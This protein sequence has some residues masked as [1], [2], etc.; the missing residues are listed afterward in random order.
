MQFRVEL[1]NVQH[2]KQLALEIDL[3]L[4]KITCLVGRNGTGKTTL[5]RALRNL[6]QSDTFLRTARA[7]IFG[8]DSVIRYFVEGEQITFDYDQ[9]LQNLNFKGNISQS[10]QDLC[11]VELPIPDGERFNF[12]QSISRA[13]RHIRRQIILEEYDRP[14]EL[15]EFLSTIY[16]T[17]KFRSLVETRIGPHSYYCILLEE[18]RYVREDYLSSGEYFLISLYRMIRGT[19]RLIVVDEIDISLD[20]AAQVHLLKKLREFCVKYQCNIF[21]TTHS[22]AMMRTLGGGELFYMEQR[23]AETTLNAVSYS[24]VKS[25]LFGFN[26]WDRYI[27]TEDIVLGEFL[28][29]LIRSCCQNVFFEYK[30][31]HIGGGQQVVDLLARNRTEQFLSEPQNVIAVL[32]GDQAR[33]KIARE[34]NVYCLPFKN[35]EVALYECYKEDGFPYKLDDGKQYNGPKD[36]FNSL[37]RDRVASKETIYQ[38]V[39]E[40]NTEVLKPLLAKL[41]KFLSEE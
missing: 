12:F 5:I 11:A 15:I 19:A 24:Y 30:I 25:R 33:G 35:V 9:N 18:S 32:D 31:I 4:N 2:I 27:I 26:G 22:L 14:E 23:D 16:S 17:N 3:S 20:A 10:I 41:G 7:G 28:A 29:T 13:D 39:I 36:L 37:Q 34:E 38:C 6:S 1:H 8:P 40:K 21:F